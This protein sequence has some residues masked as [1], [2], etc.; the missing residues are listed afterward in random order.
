MINKTIQR[1]IGIVVCM[2][3]TACVTTVDASLPYDQLPEIT[4][5]TEVMLVASPSQPTSEL[6]FEPVPA[7]ATIQLL[8]TDQDAAWLLVLHND[9]I[10]WMPTVFARTNVATLPSAVV[11]DPLAGDCT[12]YIDTTADP[13]QEWTSTIEGSLLVLGS[14]YRPQRATDFT[15]ASLK[16]AMAGGGTVVDSDYIHTPLTASSA[17]VFFAYEIKDLEKGDLISFQLEN[18]SSEPFAFQAIYFS[19]SCQANLEQLSIGVAKTIA[20]ASTS[21]QTANTQQ[22]APVEKPPVIVHGTYIWSVRAAY[23]DDAAAVLV[24]GEIVS[25]GFYANRTQGN[26]GWIDIT[27]Q[28]NA[29]EPN[30]LTLMGLNGAV[31]SSWGFYLRRGETIIWGEEGETNNEYTMSYAKTIEIDVDGT[32]NVL[33]PLLPSQSPSTDEWIVRVQDTDNLS[34]VLVNGQ[35]VGGAFFCSDCDPRERPR[36]YDIDITP[37]LSTANEN[38]VSMATWNGEGPFSYYFAL[39]QNGDVVWQ[40]NRSGTEAEGVGQVFAETVVIAANGTVQSEQ[41]TDVVAVQPNV[42]DD[43]ECNVVPVER[44]IVSNAFDSWAVGELP[45]LTGSDSWAQYVVADPSIVFHDGKFH[46]WFNGQA[47]QDSSWSI[48]YASSDNGNDWDVHSRPVMTPDGDGTWEGT[49]MGSPSVIVKDGRFEMYYFS[50]W[51]A[52]IGLATSEDGIQWEKSSRNPVLV[53]NP[54]IQW[55]SYNLYYPSVLYHDGAYEMWF[56][57]SGG[58]NWQD[59]WQIGHAVSDDGYNWRVSSNQPV[60]SLGSSSSWKSQSTAAPDVILIEDTYHMWYSG[61]SKTQ[62]DDWRIGHATSSD[63][64][65]WTDDLNNPVFGLGAADGFASGRV[66]NPAVAV[67]R[68]GYHLW[69][70]GGPGLQ[71]GF[72]TSRDGVRWL[73]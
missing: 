10:G 63:G 3:L 58:K 67:S 66:S 7:G 14:L 56:A 48:G 13:A 20:S 73:R 44:C 8:G 29:D 24:N 49:N 12:K 31:V 9:K 6:P 34:A 38:E 70:S 46:L 62:P 72:A 32:V 60:I 43:G 64:L 53:P 17:I 52:S 33:D 21:T 42:S 59:S 2:A 54:N 50:G 39:E 27:D 65:V 69:Y 68:E 23:I 41:A 35:P 22:S 71:L 1:L 16:I 45:E 15:A 26:T 57:G 36:A 25:V 11:F 51:P 28:M 47:S 55:M 5:A 18:P 37:Y 40:Q 19:D 4:V 30:R 61:R